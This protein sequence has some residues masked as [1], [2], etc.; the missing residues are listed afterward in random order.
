MFLLG[1]K[2]VLDT[3]DGQLIGYNFN[4]TWRKWATF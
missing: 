1:G 2:I 3:N 4:E